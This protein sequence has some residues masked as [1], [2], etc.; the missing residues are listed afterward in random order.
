MI[1]AKCDHQWKLYVDVGVRT[2]IPATYKCQKCATVLTAS[3]VHQLEALENQ[4]ETLKHLKGFQ[5][6][7]AVIALIISFFALVIS[8]LK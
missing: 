2:E 7:A 5:S 3:D 6:F 1:E 4:N 8:I